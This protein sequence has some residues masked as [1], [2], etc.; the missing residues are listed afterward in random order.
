MVKA[1]RNCIDIRTAG[2]VSTMRMCSLTAICSCVDLSGDEDHREVIVE[3]CMSM[4]WPP[5]RAE[6]FK[7]RKRVQHPGDHTDSDQLIALK[8]ALPESIACLLICFKKRQVKT[9]DSGLPK[10]ESDV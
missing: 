4:A 1:P 8:T 7:S 9:R 3:Y 6:N 10:C 5:V 2:A